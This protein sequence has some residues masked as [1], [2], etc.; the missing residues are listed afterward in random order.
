MMWERIKAWFERVYYCHH[1]ARVLADFE[2]RMACVLTT[3]T[4]TMSKP[5]YTI[6]AMQAEINDFMQKQY[7]EGYADGQED[8]RAELAGEGDGD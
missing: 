4:S 8:L 1:N 5:Y 7:D 6:E 3:C 2:Y